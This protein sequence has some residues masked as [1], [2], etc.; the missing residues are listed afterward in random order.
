MLNTK[1]L[2]K[3]EIAGRS[4]HDAS[5]CTPTFRTKQESANSASN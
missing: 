5:G 1:K 4:T 2:E 3:L